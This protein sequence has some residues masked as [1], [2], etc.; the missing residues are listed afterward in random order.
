MADTEK[1]S[2]GKEEPVMKFPMMFP[3]KIMGLSTEE[4]KD[5]VLK[6]THE[7][8]DDFDEK[9]LETDFSAKKKYMAL[10]V[11]VNAKSREQLDN[12][13]RAL[14]SCPLVKYAL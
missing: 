14:T 12:Y 5:T 6:I 13:Y 2:E 4:F 10:T 3:V 9:T 7:H 8:F 1:K 11:T